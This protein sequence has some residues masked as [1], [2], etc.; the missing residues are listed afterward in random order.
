MNWALRPG[1]EDEGY[2]L[3]N[4]DR[5]RPAQRKGNK[6]NTKTIVAAV[7]GLILAAAGA[8]AAS[9]QDFA[10]TH[11]RRAEVN[12]R[13]DRQDARIAEARADG[14]MGSVKAH[15]LRRADHRIR[16]TERRL[17]RRHGGHISK[18]EQARLNHRENAV[19]RR[20]G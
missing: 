12:Q 17:A 6:M 14:A 8:Q 5:S 16:V 9:A 2:L 7:A 3:R 13:L 15:R 4:A 11:P 18:M 1:S 10:Q 20:I 19:S